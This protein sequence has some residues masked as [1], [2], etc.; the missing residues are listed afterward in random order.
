MNKLVYTISDIDSVKNLFRDAYLAQFKYA[1][2]RK[3]YYCGITNN[4]EERR[5]WHNVEEYIKT[6]ECDSFETASEMERMLQDE[7]FYVGDS[8][9]HGRNDTVFVYMYKII[10]GVTRETAD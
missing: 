9:G 3:N 10:P 1:E 8:V 7:G 2:T 5:I 4:L 6:I